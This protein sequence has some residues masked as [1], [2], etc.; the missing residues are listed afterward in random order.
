[1]RDIRFR[2]WD[3]MLNRMITYPRLEE[4]FMHYEHELTRYA[5]MQFTG[6]YD[7]NKKP[8]FEGDILKDYWKEKD[9]NIISKVIWFN[10]GW[11]IENSLNIYRMD[12]SIGNYEIIGDVYTTPKLFKEKQ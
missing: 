3:K 9:I 11:H 8:V 1:M 7:K 2:C 4:L 5:L 12:E 6:L 10:F